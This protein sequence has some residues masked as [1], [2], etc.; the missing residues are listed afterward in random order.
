VAQR[1]GAVAQAALAGQVA[2]ACC[3]RPAI[4]CGDAAGAIGIAEVRHQRDLIHL[5][6]RIQAGSRRRGSAAGVKPSRFMP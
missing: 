6:Q 4:W 3:R 2:R 1:G 5:R